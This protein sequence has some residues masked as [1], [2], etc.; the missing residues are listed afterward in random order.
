[1]AIHEP[2]NILLWLLEESP[3]KVG[4]WLEPEPERLSIRACL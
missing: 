2:P 3:G 4:D 1:M